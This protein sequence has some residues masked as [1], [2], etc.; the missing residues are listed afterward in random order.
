M[1]R[2]SMFRE[3]SG[4]PY[5][6]WESGIDSRF[7]Q[8]ENEAQSFFYRSASIKEVQRLKAQQAK[9]GDPDDPV[10]QLEF[11]LLLFS[12]AVIDYDYI[13]RLIAASTHN[14]PGRQK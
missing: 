10:Q 12:S 11:E 7:H 13:M 5:A 1:I 14:Q 8:L 4:S 2:L 6:P 9:G 3:R